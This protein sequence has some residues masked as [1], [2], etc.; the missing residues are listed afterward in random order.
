MR[1]LRYTI[2]SLHHFMLTPIRRSGNTYEIFMHT[3]NFSGVYENARNNEVAAQLN[4]SD[5]KIL[6]PDHIL[7]EDQ[8]E[9]DKYANY[10]QY[11]D[12]G[13]PWHN[14]YVS[15]RNHLRAL[16]ALQQLAIALEEAS[17]QRQGGEYND[18]MALGDMDSA[19]VYGRRIEHALEYSRRNPLHAEKFI[20]GHLTASNV[21]VLE[22]PLR[23]RRVRSSGDEHYRDSHVPSPDEQPEH[24][25]RTPWV[26]RQIYGVIEATTGGYVWNHNDR[27]NVYCRPHSYLDTAK[28]TQLVEAPSGY[29]R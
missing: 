26:L 27:D 11:M 22:V 4:F 19:L 29:H 24:V 25:Y 23:F 14:D 5:W 28:S 21:T 16:H 8:D 2:H 13:D 10:E 12:M 15:F 17:H 6:K 18:R 20:Y 3:Y 9:Y 7:V 1:S